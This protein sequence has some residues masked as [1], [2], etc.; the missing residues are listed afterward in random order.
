MG[1]RQLGQSL[2][3][4][5]GDTSEYFD[6]GDHFALWLGSDIGRGIVTRRLFI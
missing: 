4:V 2:L 1:G 6:I 3:A 5:G